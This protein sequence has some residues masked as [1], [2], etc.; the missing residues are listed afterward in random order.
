MAEGVDRRMQ[1]PP[2]AEP[3]HQED[4]AVLR[5]FVDEAGDFNFKPAPNAGTRHFILTSV[6]IPQESTRCPV[7]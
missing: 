5:L 4:G 3:R 1:G 6:S 2:G 7:S